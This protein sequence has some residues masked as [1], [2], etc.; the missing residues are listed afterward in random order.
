MSLGAGLAY[1]T[2]IIASGIRDNHK[3]GVV[4][5]FPKTPI[6]QHSHLSIVSAFFGIYAYLLKEHPERY[7]R[8]R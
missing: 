5:D 3:A 1:V 6:R 2:P 7:Q 4:A 8:R